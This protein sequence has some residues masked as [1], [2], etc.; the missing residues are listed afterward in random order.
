MKTV[1]VTGATGFLGKH[2]VAQLS[3]AEPETRLR[4]LC[5]SAWPGGEPPESVEIARGDITSPGDVDRAAEGVA[6]IYHLAGIVQREPKDPGLLYKTHVEGTRNVCEAVKRHRVSKAVFVSTSGTVAVGRTPVER[7]ETAGY[8]IETVGAWPYYTSKIYAEKL[9]LRYIEADKLPI[10]IVNPSLLL[11]PGDDRLSSTGDVALFLEGQIMAIPSGGLNLVD[12]RDVAAAV[13]EAMRRGRVGKRYLLG[14]DELGVSGVDRPHG[15]GRGS[16]APDDRAASV[17]GAG[18]R[19]AVAGGDAVGRQA[20]QTRRRVDQNVGLLL[21]LQLRQGAKGVRLHHSRPDG[22]AARHDR[23]HSTATSGGITKPSGL[24]LRP[25]PPE[26][27]HSPLAAAYSMNRH[28]S[29]VRSCAA[30][31][32]MKNGYVGFS[33]PTDR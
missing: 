13:I 26:S 18:E 27:N 16:Q 15:P 17:V 1:L 31:A 23:L 32:I 20:I 33:C 5:R 11:G 3:R 19:Q 2:L 29:W 4:L 10:V 21:V 28:A 12:V 24:F 7:D 22:H 6:E 25:P 8:A 9:A 14:G 30:D